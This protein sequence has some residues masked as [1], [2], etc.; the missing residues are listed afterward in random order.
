M[1]M[2]MDIAKFGHAA[3]SFG[4]SRHPAAKPKP[5]DGQPTVKNTLFSGTLH[6]TDTFKKGGGDD[7]CD[8]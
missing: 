7:C 8:G 5:E 6:K 3:P 4:Q 2:P 1:G